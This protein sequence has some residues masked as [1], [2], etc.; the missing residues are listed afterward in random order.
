MTEKQLMPVDKENLAYLAANRKETSYQQR[1][2]LPHKVAEIMR[3]KKSELHKLITLET[4]PFSGEID[5][6]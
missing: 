5:L 3:V 4:N 1:A 6:C 2:D